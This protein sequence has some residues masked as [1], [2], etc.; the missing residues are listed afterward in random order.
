MKFNPEC[1]KKTL[2]IWLRNTDTGC[3]YYDFREDGLFVYGWIT[4]EQAKM[5]HDWNEAHKN[6]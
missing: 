4:P 6:D 3:S 2:I 5:I 1:D